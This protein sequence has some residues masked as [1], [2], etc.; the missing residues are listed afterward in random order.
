[1]AIALLAGLAACAVGPENPLSAQQVDALE[2]NQINVKIVPGA[3]ILWGAAEEDFAESK[4]CP[5]P[6]PESSDPGDE[7]NVAAATATNPDCD[8]DALVDS[9]EAR[10]YLENRVQNV[11]TAA[12]DKQVRNN[13][14]GTDAT[15]LDVDVSRVAIVSG[16][17]SVLVGGAHVLQA[18]FTIVDAGSGTTLATYPDLFSQAGYAPGGLLSLI[19][20]A[21]SSDP[22][23]RLSAEYA[24]GVRNWLKPA[25]N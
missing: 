12:L 21:T 6:E 20:E 4:G 7:Y 18:T 13:F 23:E 17:Q 9:P 14:K 3:V 24:S 19:V 5:R 11:L 1:M 2:I 8:Y 10:T 22:F 16:G 25:A 15:R